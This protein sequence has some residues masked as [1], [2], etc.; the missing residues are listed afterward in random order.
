MYVH[1]PRS[2]LEFF[3]LSFIYLLTSSLR[4][5]VKSDTID[6]VNFCLLLITQIP[7]KLFISK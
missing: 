3:V 5:L 7:L 2:R 6:L 1:K 4:Y